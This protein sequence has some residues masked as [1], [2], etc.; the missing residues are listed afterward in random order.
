ML[1]ANLQFLGQSKIGC[2]GL[3]TSL[4]SYT[5]TSYHSKMIINKERGREQITISIIWMTR[6]QFL[7]L[8]WNWIQRCYTP[9]P[10]L[11][12]CF[13]QKQQHHGEL[14]FGKFEKCCKKP[15]K[16]IQIVK[17]QCCGFEPLFLWFWLQLGGCM[18]W[19]YVQSYYQ[20]KDKC[21]WET[22]KKLCKFGQNVTSF[23]LT[24]FKR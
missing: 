10:F 16:K 9:N 4:I 17:R 12:I 23:T 8:L 5:R 1:V 24:I 21:A 15:H 11:T 14:F 6:F 3:Y 22:A 20:T 2:P 13:V 18:S 7:Y 19:Y